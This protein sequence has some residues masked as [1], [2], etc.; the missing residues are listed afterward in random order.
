MFELLNG[1]CVCVC[2]WVCVYV[3]SFRWCTRMC[4][5]SRTLLKMWKVSQLMASY[6][7]VCVFWCPVCDEIKLQPDDACYV[8][9]ITC[10]CEAFPWSCPERSFQIFRVTQKTKNKRT[11]LH[12]YLQTEKYIEFAALKSSEIWAVIL[13]K[14]AR[15]KH[16]FVVKYK[17]LLQSVP[18]H[19]RGPSAAYPWLAYAPICRHTANPVWCLTIPLGPGRVARWMVMMVFWWSAASCCCYCYVRETLCWGHMFEHGTSLLAHWQTRK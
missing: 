14:L 4:F 13:R 8:Y 18:M 6:M 12:D 7:C 3:V 11:D 2:E 17:C 1:W 10:L 9:S 16:S 19:S 15:E 5:H